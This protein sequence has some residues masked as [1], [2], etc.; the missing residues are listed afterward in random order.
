MKV[1]LQKDVANLGNIGDLVKVKDGYGRNFLLPRGL[2]VLADESNTR[3]LNHQKRLAKTLAAKQLAA[4]EAAAK[5][6][7][8]TPVAF[9]LEAG[10]D[11]KVFGSVTSR[12]IAEAL[13]AKGVEVDRRKMAMEGAL[14]EIGS[15]DVAVDLGSGVTANIRVLIEKK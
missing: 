11:D 13:A 14:K 7:E 4:A 9:K 12:D 15:F 8:S 10:E 3:Q 6:I 1:I 2:A 5:T